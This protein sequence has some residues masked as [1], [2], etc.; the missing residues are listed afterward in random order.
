M[1]EIALGFISCRVFSQVTVMT[2]L[3]WLAPK[4]I[5]PL[6]CITIVGFPLVFS[7]ETKAFACQSTRFQK[8]QSSECLKNRQYAS[9]V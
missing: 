9:H 6:L 4:Q 3:S 5:G 2:E 7:T 1:T 8:V